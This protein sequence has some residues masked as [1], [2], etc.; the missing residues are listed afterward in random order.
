MKKSPEEIVRQNILSNMIKRLGY[1]KA[2]LCVEKSLKDLR[3]ENIERS[4]VP[5]RRVDILCYLKKELKPLIL[6]ECK[7][8]VLSDKTISQVIGY[9]KYVGAPYIAIANMDTILTGFY[10][11]ERKSYRFIKSLPSYED[12]SRHA[13]VR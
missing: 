1:P 4:K 8:E 3:A 2:L 12:L 5:N 9:N 11:E 6:I 7:A 13:F 10:D